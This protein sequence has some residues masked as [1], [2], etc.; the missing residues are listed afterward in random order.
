LTHNMTRRGVLAALMAGVSAPVWAE[1]PLTSLRPR[2]R[3]ALVPVAAAP[4]VGLADL[5]QAADLGGLTGVVV[6]D[7]ATGVVLESHAPDVTLPPASVA[8]SITSLFALEKLGPDHRFTTRV[9]ATGPVVNGVVQGD[10]ILAGGGDPTLGADDLGDM[11]ARLKAK[12]VRGVTGTYLVWD[13]ALPTLDRIAEDQPDHVGYNPGLSGLM[14]DFDRVYFEWKRAGDGY[15]T[16]MDARGERFA[17]KVDV[18]R[19]QVENRKDPLFTYRMGQSTEDWTVARGALG[20]DGSRWLPVRRPGPYVAEAFREL[21]AMQGI[22]LP[23]AQMIAAFPAKPTELIRK[24]SEPLAVVLRGMLRWSTNITAE[25]V[26]LAASQAASLSVSGQVMT[27]WAKGAL[28]HPGDF[29]DHSGLG[30]QSR[31]TAQGMARALLAGRGRPNGAHLPGILR[32]FGLT[33]EKGK[34]MKDSPVRVR[35]K[36]G[37]LNFT[38]GLAGFIQPPAGRELVF[39]IFSSDVDRRAALPMA[40]REE[41]PGG[42]AWLKRARR[43]QAQ[44]LRRWAESYCA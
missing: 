24:D 28:G 39:A 16:S 41:P 4:A 19:M 10:L 2:P 44:L 17:P 8:K 20:T 23:A 35:A 6:L 38:S 34:P 27:D 22:N 14:L 5:V 29:V 31:V 43:L 26:G 15:T 25:A 21:C 13:R 42:K 36:T 1:A 33:D 3:A 9:L 7:A 30:S 32:E 11:A 18:T 37:T 12:G 40:D